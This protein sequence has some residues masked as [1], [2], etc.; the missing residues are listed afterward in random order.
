MP[1]IMAIGGLSDCGC[2]SPSGTGHMKPLRA[3]SHAG[4]SVG[5][6]VLEGKPRG[7]SGLGRARGRVCIEV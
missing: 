5:G 3:G 1:R 7:T 6:V 4:G 2:A